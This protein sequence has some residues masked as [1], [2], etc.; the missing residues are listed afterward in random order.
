MQNFKGIDLTKYVKTGPDQNIII[1]LLY[2]SA[3]PFTR[4]ALY[5]RI[6]PNTL[7][8]MSSILALLAGVALLT[9]ENVLA[10]STLFLLSIILDFAD[11][12]V[13]RATQNV[14]KS[15][16][17]YDHISD[18]FKI[19]FVVIC[20]STEF[21]D[22]KIWPIASISLSLFLISTVLNHDFGAAKKSKA[23]QGAIF[24]SG[25]SAMERK[26]QNFKRNIFSIFMTY[27]SHTLLFFAGIVFYPNF[28]LQLFLYLSAI[29]L[30]TCLRFTILLRKIKL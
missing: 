6:S 18:L 3:F 22:E 14:G 28:A 27:D 26:K 10:F 30:Y 9:Y 29:S 4:I 2:L 23:S 19:S 16:L 11:G 5:F 25:N 1:W 8:T 20:L 12:L 21:A 17:D 15:A 13:A 24:D 7:T